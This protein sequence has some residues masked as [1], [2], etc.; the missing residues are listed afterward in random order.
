MM[1]TNWDLTHLYK[2]DDAWGYSCEELITKLDVLEKSE[3]VFLK[4]IASFYDFLN[5]KIEADE[6]IERI[7]CYPKRH[8]DIDLTLDKYNNMF[9]RALE[10]YRRIQKI[11]S[12]FESAIISNNTLV[13]NYL[14]DSKLNKYYRYIYLILRRNA[15]IL[16]E[17]KMDI[18]TKYT[19]NE[20]KIKSSY[21]N[22]FNDEIQ[23]KTALV[24]GNVI[25]INKQNYSDLILDKSQEMRKIV[26]DTYTE[27]YIK[28]NDI[29]ANLYIEKLN[30]DITVSKLENYDSLLSKKLFELELPNSI[31]DNLINSVNKNLSVMHDYTSFKKD[32]IGLKDF[33]VYDTTVSIC[34]IPKM[35]LNLEESLDIIKNSLGILGHDYISLIDKMFEEGWVDVYPSTHKR[36]MPFTC[37]SYVGV[38]YILIN[39]NSSINSA[40]TLAHEIGHAIHTFYSK[41]N[42]PFEYYEFSCFLTEIAS[43]VNEIL[44]N[45]Y[46][47]KNCLNHQEKIYILNNVISALGNSLFGQVMLTEFEHNVINKLLNT[48]PVSTEYLNDLYLNL[49]KKYNGPSLNYDDNV[50]YGWLKI[51]HFFMSD[52][53][54]LYQYSIGTAIATNIAYRILENKDDIIIKYKKFLSF[55]NSVSIKEALEYIDIDLNDNKYIDDTIDVLKTKIKQIRNLTNVKN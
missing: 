36:T 13:T 6:L 42:N 4:D 19:D 9:Q 55:G 18:Y 35:E 25:E 15:H 45:E 50:K 46:M 20:H 44:V 31:V 12:I 8:L 23:F 54:Y 17:D 10:L 49:S 27:A 29:L 2:N 24:N 41:T 5:L 26:F 53:Y 16:L 38:P 51:P 40:R 1:K 14:K 43:K 30:N 52:V 22:L 11:N 7:Y 33:H 21:Q 28:A 37:I 32:I 47:L 34:E 3:K 48:E 39:Y